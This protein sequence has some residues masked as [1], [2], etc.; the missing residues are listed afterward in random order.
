LPFRVFGVDCS[1][2]RVAA[3]R[4]PLVEFAARSEYS[5]R[6]SIALMG[7]A[8]P[9]CRWPLPQ[10]YGFSSPGSTDCCSSNP[11]HPLVGF[12]VPPEFCSV[13]PSRPVSTGR[14]LS[15][16]FAPFS[17]CRHRRSTSCECAAL[18]TV[19]TS[20]VGYPLDGLLPSIPGRPCFRSTALMG[21]TLRSH[22]SVGSFARCHVNRP[23]YRFSCRYSRC[24]DRVGP[25]GRGS[26]VRPGGS[27][28]RRARV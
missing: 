15:W 24:Y 9:F 21:F 18:T 10:L 5:A 17:T 12:R 11:F 22:P 27:S 4:R 14:L 16:A 6:R 1:T 25:A 2:F 3:W 7:Y 8:F 28:F 19:P 26:R 23:A 20:G 13:N